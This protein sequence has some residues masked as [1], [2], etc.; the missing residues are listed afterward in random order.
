MTASGTRP[1]AWGLALVLLFAACSRGVIVER[2][3]Q[4][5]IFSMGGSSREYWKGNAKVGRLWTAGG[6][7]LCRS[8]PDVVARIVSIRPV[9][10]VGAMRVVAIHVR[11]SRRPPADATFADY[12]P[13][14]HLFNGP[15]PAPPNA[16][17]PPG[18]WSPPPA[19]RRGSARS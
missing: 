1:W 13:L 5:G 19:T 10:V 2:D 11:T 7:T 8:E 9:E 4:G 3:G 16:L 14:V 15:G 18:T 6:V 17:P 12:D